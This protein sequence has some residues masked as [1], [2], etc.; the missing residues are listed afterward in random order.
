MNPALDPVCLRPIR[1]EPAAMSAS[2]VPAVKEPARKAR[3]SS[4]RRTPRRGHLSFAEGMR[5]FIGV[6]KNAPS[7][8]SMC[9]GFGK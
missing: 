8:L 2:S 7:D 1:C 5:P 3:S 9:V 6:I 4:K